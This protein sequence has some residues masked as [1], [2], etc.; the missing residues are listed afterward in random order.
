M[1]IV[2]HKQTLPNIN[3]FPKKIVGTTVYGELGIYTF[4]ESEVTFTKRVKLIDMNYGH[5]LCEGKGLFKNSQLSLKFRLPKLLCFFWALLMLSSF[6]GFSYFFWN[7]NPIIMVITAILF[8]IPLLIFLTR[9]F[10]EFEIFNLLT[11]EIE[12]I[13]DEE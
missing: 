1:G 6:I 11:A 12:D 13:L 3:S 5:S 7:W 2:I 8:A 4:T 9:Y 10:S